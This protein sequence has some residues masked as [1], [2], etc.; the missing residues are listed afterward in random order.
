MV[1][2]K[3][4]QRVDTLFYNVPARRKFLKSNM[5]ETGYIGDC[6][7]RLAVSHPEIAFRF[8]SGGK[9]ILFPIGHPPHFSMSV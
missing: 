7:N 3:A 5:T 1:L 9:T 6:L 2:D 8:I 4:L